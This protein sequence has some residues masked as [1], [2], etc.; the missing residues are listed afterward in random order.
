MRIAITG[1]R[2][3]RPSPE[4]MRR[5]WDIWHELGATSLVHG[6]CNKDLFERTGEIRG[7]DM[8][9]GEHV[10]GDGYEVIEVPVDHQLDGPW[11]F[12][13]PRRNRRMLASF[14]ADLLV[15][16]PGGKGTRDCVAAAGELGIEVRRV[17]C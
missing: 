11:P 1:G 7:V 3:Y 8:F 10:R 9:V 16:F 4:E 14:H 2:D 17:A 6:A 5:F 13:G 15:A 12:A